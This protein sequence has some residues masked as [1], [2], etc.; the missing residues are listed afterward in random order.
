MAAVG[1]T[2]ISLYYTTTPGAA[3]SAANLANAELA[4]NITDGK[5]YYKDNTGTVQLLASKSAAGGAAGGANTQVQYN[6]SGVLAGS[7]N[8]TFNGTSLT[9]G[10]NPTLSAGTANGVLFLNA[11]KV[12]TSGTDFAYNGNCLSIGAT[13]AD[14]GFSKALQLG[15]YGNA[16][17]ENYDGYTLGFLFRATRNSSGT[18]IGT[19]LAASFLNQTG[20]SFSWS[21]DPTAT[22][23]NPVT[24]VE[25]M[26]LDSSGNLTAAG[27]ISDSKGD[28][29]S[30]PQTSTSA[31]Y[32]LLSTDNGKHINYT[33]NNG[34][35]EVPALGAVSSGYVATIFNNTNTT[36]TIYQI[37]GSTLR[38]AGTTNTGNRTLSAYGLATILCVATNTYVISGT[39]LA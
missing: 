7:A 5:L 24:F 18:L 2:P 28:V 29:R 19:G 35:V 22:A 27:I 4:I 15:I 17:V 14:W 21:F 34:S 12:A 37:G 13:P 33:L 16:A 1:F 23:G 25:K 20:S 3:P 8:L 38:Q 6:N 32:I 36:I 39:G 9:L 11:S 31:N 10:G 26:L 30:I